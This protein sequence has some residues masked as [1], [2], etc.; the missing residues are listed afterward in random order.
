MNLRSK[1][2]ESFN[3]RNLK[4]INKNFEPHSKRSTYDLKHQTTIKILNSLNSSFDSKYNYEDKTDRIKKEKIT[5]SMLLHEELKNIMK[6]K[7]Q[8]KCNS[9]KPVDKTDNDT[10]E[11][12]NKI[13]IYQYNKKT[14]DLK[15]KDNKSKMSSALN[16]L[17]FSNSNI[18]LGSKNSEINFNFN[19]NG[20]SNININNIITLSDELI[21]KDERYIKLLI[22]RN[23]LKSENE[24]LLENLSDYKHS[25]DIFNHYIKIQNVKN[26]LN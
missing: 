16:D 25:I 2:D 11:K 24:A 4:T 20:Y 12:K 14:A 21:Y 18:S 8:S 7:Q 23:K 6:K 15:F 22:E 10:I 17:S 1:N 26:N 3:L 13:P 19:D 5:K 9:P